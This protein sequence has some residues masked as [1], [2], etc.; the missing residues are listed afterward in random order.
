MKL[1]SLLH[2][3]LVLKGYY[4][5]YCPNVLGTGLRV[6]NRN[7]ETLA[8]SMLSLN[9]ETVLPLDALWRQMPSTVIPIYLMDFQSRFIT[10]HFLIVLPDNSEFLSISYGTDITRWLR[11]ELSWNIYPPP[12]PQKKLTFCRLW[13]CYTEHTRMSDPVK[14]NPVSVF[15]VRV[16]VNFVHFVLV[17]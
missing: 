7:S 10:C 5:Y 12:P 17:L 9:V 16:S 1:T 2:G 3:F 15:C 6:P 13:H 8:C 11:V 14:S 4:Y